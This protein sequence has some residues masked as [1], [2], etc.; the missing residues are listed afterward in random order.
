M[1]LLRGPYKGLGETHKALMRYVSEHKVNTGGV[2]VMAIEEYV[3][4]AMSDPNPE[5]FVTNVYYLHN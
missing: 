3:V 2:P 1:A 5:H 4:D